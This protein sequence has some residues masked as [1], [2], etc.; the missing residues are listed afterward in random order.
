MH[1]KHLTLL[2]SLDSWSGV[3]TTKLARSASEGE[4]FKTL[5]RN[6]RLLS[7]RPRWR[8]GLFCFLLFH[9]L[10]TS[11]AE[12]FAGKKFDDALEQKVGRAWGGG[13]GDSI[14]QA[15]QQI[16]E[17]NHVSIVLDRR[18]DPTQSVSLTVPST[19]LRD[20]IAALA[21]TVD[22]GIVVVG[23]VVYVGPTE[24]AKK[25]R[26]LIELRNADLSKLA[27]AA[28]KNTEKS[29]WRNPSVSLAQKRTFPWKDFDRPRDILKQVAEKLKIEVD[30]LE[31]LPH[32]LWAGSSLTQ[33][34]ATEALS[35]LLIQFGATFE[36]VPDRAV[37]RIVPIPNRVVIE[38]S[39]PLANAGE[40]ARAARERF[41]DAEIIVGGANL[42]VQGTVEQHAEIAAFLKSGG[43]K[44]ANAPA[45]K[46]DKPLS[47][48]L[49]TLKLENAALGDVIKTFVANGVQIKYDPMQFADAEI[50][51]DKKIDKI[52]VKQVSAE[53]L[54][55]DLFE[56]LGIE[57]TIDGEVVRLKPR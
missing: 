44:T 10:T 53:K 22:A 43:Q 6:S 5:R 51:L 52:D 3:A 26:T 36:F 40:I 30:G 28:V 29:P 24:S 13:D 11:A 8:F 31:K 16:T 23:N 14:R 17:S 25:L 27:S 2:K 12:P 49:F 46:P 47:K 55:R 41:T 32:D 56:P 9:S 39:F 15:L 21:R 33:V 45:N 1:A 18:I 50:S 38:R 7:V 48:R 42:I 37:I 57:V 19:P 34:T 35:L 20:V 4:G 54:F